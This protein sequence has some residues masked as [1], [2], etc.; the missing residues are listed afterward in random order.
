MKAYLVKGTT[1]EVTTCELCSKPELKGTVMLAPLDEDGNEFGAVCYFGVSCAAK[2]A[3]WSQREVRAGIKAAKDEERERQRAERDAMWAAQH[4]FLAGWYLTN[5]GT[6]DLCEAAERAGVSTVELSG[7]AIRAYRESQ[8]E[9]TKPEAE[10]APA[11]CTALAIPGN[12]HFMT[13]HCVECNAHRMVR[14]SL[15]QVESWYRSGHFSQDEY[16]GYAY[17]WA[18]STYRFSQ[19]AESRVPNDPAVLRVVSAIR[20]HAALRSAA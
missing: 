20:R 19:P 17:A 7:E 9:A 15:D 18:T 14:M 10:E 5:Y 4:A 11:E 2:A 13:D 16:E 8:A 1:D 6:E 12:T 3:G